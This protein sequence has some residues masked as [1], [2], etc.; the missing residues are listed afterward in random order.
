M[1][2]IYELFPFNE[3]KR[4]I[5]MKMQWLMKIAYIYSLS[6]HNFIVIY[7]NLWIFFLP[8]KYHVIVTM[9]KYLQIILKLFLIS[10]ALVWR[11]HQFTHRKGSNSY[12]AIIKT[13]NCTIKSEM[14]KRCFKYQI[15]N[16]FII[17]HKVVYI[18]VLYLNDRQ[19]S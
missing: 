19:R 11:G 13:F 4:A 3:T 14:C 7:N 6:E 18:F 5:F 12:A 10:V 1:H 2:F 16:H 15:W 9:F 8:W 17:I